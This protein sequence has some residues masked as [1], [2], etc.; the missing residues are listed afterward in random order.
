MDNSQA[1]GTPEPTSKT[2]TGMT[3]RSSELPQ[4]AKPNLPAQLQKLLSISIVDQRSQMATLEDV[5]AIGTP[6]MRKLIEQH[7]YDDALKVVSGIIIQADIALGGDGDPSR[8]VPTAANAMLANSHRGIGF[9]IV[10]IR[11]GMKG[12]V[13]G[14][15]INASL[16]NEW[17]ATQEANIIGMAE[18]AHARTKFVDNGGRDTLD[19]D[20]HNS[21][22]DKRKMQRMSAHIEMLKA[23]IQ[24]KDE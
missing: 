2:Q 17:T 8:C 24:T 20:Q 16:L 23:T 22:A 13:Y 9:L 5:T 1:D 11:E 18:A 12:K 10:S 21:E 19:R 7:G 4:S 6:P 14:N 15:K 3:T